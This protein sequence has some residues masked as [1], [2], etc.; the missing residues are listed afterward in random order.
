[1]GKVNMFTRLGAKKGGILR[2]ILVYA[3]FADIQ[4]TGF[5]NLEMKCFQSGCFGTSPS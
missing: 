2:L 3:E 1:M 5:T 4:K